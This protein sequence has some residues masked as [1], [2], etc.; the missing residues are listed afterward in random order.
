MAP[1]YVAQYPDA[2]GSLIGIRT[3]LAPVIVS[4]W[5]TTRLA[6]VAAEEY[7]SDALRPETNSTPLTK[8]SRASAQFTPLNWV[9]AASARVGAMATALSAVSVA[10]VSSRAS[11]TRGR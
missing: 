5:P 11:R 4:S 10:T 2:G 1:V 6:T 8:L 3:V 9:V 7:V